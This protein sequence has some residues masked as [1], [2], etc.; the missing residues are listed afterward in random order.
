MFTGVDR[1]VDAN[2]PFGAVNVPDD[3]NVARF[4]V[5]LNEYTPNCTFEPLELAKN[6]VILVKVPDAC[7]LSLTIQSDPSSD[8]GTEHI[9]NGNGVSDDTVVR[10]GEVDDPNMYIVVPTTAT[11]IFAI[12]GILIVVALPLFFKLKLLL[13]P[14]V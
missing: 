5:M 14:V 13:A 10:R 6:A 3:I 8:P 12:A 7:G 2:P 11:A 1:V 4:V 9:A